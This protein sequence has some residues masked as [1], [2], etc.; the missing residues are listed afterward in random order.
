MFTRNTVRLICTLGCMTLLGGCLGTG[1]GVKQVGLLPSPA[2]LVPKSALQEVRL[3][4][5]RV[6]VRGPK[7]YCIDSGAVRKSSTAGFALLAPCTA[8]GE[9]NGDAV[10][11]AALLTLQA[12]ARLLKAGLPDGETLATSMLDLEPVYSESGDGITIV[13]LAK[14]G[15]K[16]MPGGDPKHWRAVMNFNG[17]LVGITV[18]SVKGGPAAGREGKALLLAFAERVRAASPIKSVKPVKTSTRSQL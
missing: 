5:S 10:Q 4:G 12:R 13:Q 8:L 14:G 18:Y 9:K 7:G 3:L 15:D 16:Y 2:D 17:A 11:T 1:Q 6:T